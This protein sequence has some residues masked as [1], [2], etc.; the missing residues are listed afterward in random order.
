MNSLCLH[1]IST[2][3]IAILLSL[4]PGSIVAQVDSL[5]NSRDSINIG[6]PG[7][8]A[9]AGVDTSIHRSA[10]LGI[11]NL[12][13]DPYPDTLWGFMDRN[14]HL[15]PSSIVWGRRDSSRENQGSADT[16]TRQQRGGRL[17]VSRTVIDYPHWR[18]I[19]GSVSIQRLNEDS[20]PDIIIYLWAGF[21][22]ARLSTILP[23]H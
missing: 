3:L 16:M 6:V 10:I 8:A 22:S 9:P 21:R 1:R 19:T 23:V 5:H 14:F 13:F 18:T 12:N 15:L 2:A 7:D 20:L 11:R 4:C 17:P